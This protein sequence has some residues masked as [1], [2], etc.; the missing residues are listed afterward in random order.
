M[1]E[2]SSPYVLRLAYAAVRNRDGSNIEILRDVAIQ[3]GAAAR[4]QPAIRLI[5]APLLG[6]G[7]G[8]VAH[9]PAVE[10]LAVGFRNAAPDEATLSL[11]TLHKAVFNRLQEH[12]ATALITRAQPLRVFLSYT[13]SDDHET[14]HWVG[15]LAEFLTGHGIDAR[16][17]KWH[18]HKG[19]DLQHW[20]NRELSSADKVIVVCDEKYAAKADDRHGGV[21]WETM[22][23]QNDL[24]RLSA[25]TRKYVVIARSES[26]ETALPYY[27][28]G[29][30]VIH[31]R[32]TDKLGVPYEDLLKELYE[33]P[34][35][36]LI[37][38]RP[39]YL[40]KG[41]VAPDSPR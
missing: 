28:R 38:E 26:V 41:A 6:T 27:L 18:L 35:A 4:S 9:I 17:D 25:D 39:I 14:S 11:S 30:F 23:I 3:L 1:L 33:V 40:L 7:A 36:P 10:A 32:P 19:M 13:D 21:G 29:R 22:L 12:F 16:F 15:V 31:V 2:L 20:M 5:S 8:G 34:I 24:A 37:G